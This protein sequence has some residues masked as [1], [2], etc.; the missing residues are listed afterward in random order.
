MKKG[1]LILLLAISFSVDAQS[2]K[3]L[4]Y[5][6]KLKSDSNTVVRK[7]DDLSAKIDTATKKPV[8][9]K[10]V[11]ATVTKSDTVA[12]VKA[13]GMENIPDSNLTYA[14]VPTE[15]KVA[16][17]KSNTKLWKEYTD[18]L[19]AAMKA[20]EVLA[21]KKLKKGTYYITLDYELGTDGKVEVLNVFSS[22]EN[23]FLQNQV[24]DRLLNNPPYLAPILDSAGNPRK[25]KRKQNFVVTKE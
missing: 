9:E 11:M 14:P 12:Q 23:E 7:S 2:L 18:S 22:P 1:I 17:P 20:E 21:S 10:P 13:D 25:V 5:S 24:K 3:D 19:T 8:A 6:G 16:A 15:A 4:L